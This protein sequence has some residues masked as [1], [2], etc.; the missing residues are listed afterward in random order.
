MTR[1]LYPWQ[2][3][4]RHFFDA[5]GASL[6]IIA[7]LARRVPVPLGFRSQS[8][9][10]ASVDSIGYPQGMTL[11]RNRGTALRTRRSA[12]RMESVVRRSPDK[13]ESAFSAPFQTRR[14]FMR[15][16]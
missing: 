9:I 16:F 7:R 6:S 3:R 2:F 12:G 1:G 13:F 11:G 10:V 8:Q 15:G 4:R 5:D 14:H